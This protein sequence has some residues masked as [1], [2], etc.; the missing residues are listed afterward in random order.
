MNNNEPNAEGIVD[1]AVLFTMGI[2]FGGLA[3][4][5]G[6]P[7]PRDR[8]LRRS[9]IDLLLNSIKEG[10]FGPLR[11]VQ[12]VDGLYLTGCGF[13]HPVDSPE[14]AEAVIAQ[15][16][17]DLKP[18]L[19][20]LGADAL[21]RLEPVD[22]IDVADGSC[23]QGTAGTVDGYDA[24]DDSD[25]VTWHDCTETIEPT[26]D[27]CPAPTAATVVAREHAA[28]PAAQEPIAETEQSSVALVTDTPAIA[29]AAEAPPIGP[30]ARAPIIAPAVE[31]PAK[32]P[33]SSP[34]L[35]TLKPLK[36]SGRQSAL[37]HIDRT[38]DEIVSRMHSRKSVA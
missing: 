3:L 30:M 35:I 4:D 9:L 17:E 31:A 21:L 11:L 15:L 19:Q 20:G 23:P 34:C 2:L 8:T 1:S 25:D 5:M 10:S 13:M 37:A 29:P 16:I 36:Q 27:L 14:H 26:C 38:L 18:V 12:R 33:T 32:T 22:D 24:A 7:Q 28:A 6:G